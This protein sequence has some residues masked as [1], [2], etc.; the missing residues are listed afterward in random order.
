MHKDCALKLNMSVLTLL[1]LFVTLHFLTCQQQLISVKLLQFPG[2]AL[3]LSNIIAV[4]Y[5]TDFNYLR[6]VVR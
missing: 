3:A 4:F 6:H 2:M 1:L 5:T